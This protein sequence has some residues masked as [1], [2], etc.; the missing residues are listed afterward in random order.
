V[1]QLLKILGPGDRGVIIADDPGAG[2]TRMTIALL[3]ALGRETGPVLLV[4]PL[5]VLSHWHK[6]FLLMDWLPE[7]LWIYHPDHSTTTPSSSVWVTITTYRIFEAHDLADCKPSWKTVV[8]DEATILKEIDTKVTNA[9][10]TLGLLAC[11]RIL[12][13]GTP[14]QKNLTELHTLFSIIQP[15]LLGHVDVFQS[16]FTDPVRQ[17]THPSALAVDR[18]RA[19][20]LLRVL[21]NIVA[22]HILRRSVSKP[23]QKQSMVLWNCMNPLESELYQ[24]SLREMRA[25]KS[26]CAYTLEEKLSSVTAGTHPDYH[27]TSFLSAKQ[28]MILEVVARCLGDNKSIAIFTKHLNLLEWIV[29]TLKRLYPTVGVDIVHGGLSSSKREEAI[30][31]FNSKQIRVLVLTTRSS[32][33]GINL[34]CQT[35]IIAEMDWN[36]A[37]DEQ[38]TARAHRGDSVCNV[39]IYFLLTK[40]TFEERKYK[41]QLQETTVNHKFLEGITQVIVTAPTQSSM[42]VWKQLPASMSLESHDKTI[43]GLALGSQEFDHS[44]QTYADAYARLQN[45]RDQQDLRM[46][47][48]ICTRIKA[49]LTKGPQTTASLLQHRQRNDFP[50]ALYRSCLHRVAKMQHNRQWS[51]KIK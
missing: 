1:E 8:F 10:Q 48:W 38:A 32:C 25:T 9:A 15:N 39:D 16:F 26:K 37:V 17:G 24:S 29:H 28:D 12:I 42:V 22:P 49:L 33:Y 51:C 47:A 5:S 34:R 31:A 19:G 43:R 46:A 36:A 18:L 41:R 45:Q 44:C 20:K 13:T 6:E 21:Q 7:D 2:K 50:K 11:R 23:F 35:I 30:L 27:N 40:G 3:Q 4:V 14:T